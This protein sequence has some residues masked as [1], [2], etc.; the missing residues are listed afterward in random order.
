MEVAVA[1]AYITPTMDIATTS[2]CHAWQH[3]A[4]VAI[5]PNCYSNF[6]RIAICLTDSNLDYF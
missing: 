3:L 6:K 5:N 1:I 4:L 2:Y